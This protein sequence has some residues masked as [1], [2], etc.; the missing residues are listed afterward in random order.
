MSGPR[1]GPRSRRYSL[2]WAS[3]SQPSCSLTSTSRTCPTPSTV[4]RL[5]STFS[6]VQSSR[7]LA[8]HGS[9]AQGGVKDF[10]YSGIVGFPGLEPAGASAVFL[11]FLVVDQL[12]LALFDPQLE[13]AGSLGITSGRQV[14]V[15]IHLGLDLDEGCAQVLKKLAGGSEKSGQYALISRLSRWA[16]GPFLLASPPSVR[17]DCHDVMP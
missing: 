8:D 7:L 4:S 14:V 10:T 2:T 9:G 11:A 12:A 13:P 3:M 1:Q 16:I 6:L 5:K 15:G 17:L